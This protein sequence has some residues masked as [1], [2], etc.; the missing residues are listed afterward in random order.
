MMALLECTNVIRMYTNVCLVHK[1]YV[2]LGSSNFEGV[3]HS[4][5]LHQ[6][7]YFTGLTMQDKNP[8]FAWEQNVICGAELE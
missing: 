4:H 5:L 6:V 3:K 7:W 2:A 8:G 1:S